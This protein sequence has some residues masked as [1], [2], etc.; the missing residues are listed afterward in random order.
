MAD[1]A[2]TMRQ[3]KRMCK[4]YSYDD[5]VECCNGCPIT[6]LS[7]NGCD[8]IYADFPENASWNDVENVI[9]A[10]A[11]EHPEPRYPMWAEWLMAK[12]NLHETIDDLGDVLSA[13]IP[14]D[15]AEKLGIK[16]KEYA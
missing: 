3:W 11:A 9:M 2:E 5:A 16:P 4:A 14:A 1:F 12:Y 6:K 8:A 13:P 15:I 10:W 7:A